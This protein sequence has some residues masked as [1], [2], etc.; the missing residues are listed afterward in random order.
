MYVVSGG[1]ARL[2]LQADQG[3]CWLRERNRNTL[4]NIACNTHSS[5]W[6]EENGCQG[7]ELRNTEQH[8]QLSDHHCVRHVQPIVS[9]ASATT[10]H[11][12]VVG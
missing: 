5:A 11:K 2:F 3:F 10:M 12:Q 6:D 8:I 4:H 1:S 7:V 9:L